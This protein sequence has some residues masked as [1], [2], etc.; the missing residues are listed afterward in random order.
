MQIK[1]Q[2]DDNFLQ[3]KA[4]LI[5]VLEKLFEVWDIAPALLTVVKSENVTEEFCDSLIQMIA[6]AHRD[7]TDEQAKIHAQKAVEKLKK[8]REAE[9]IDR[10]KDDNYA[11]GLLNEL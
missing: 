10:S 6:G 5:E 8:L 9:K 7:F 2:K 3:K 11:E 1:T 4:I